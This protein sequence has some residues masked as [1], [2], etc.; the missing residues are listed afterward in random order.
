LADAA[1]RVLLILLRDRQLDIARGDPQC[2]HPIRFQ[3]DTHRI[4]GGAHDRCLPGPGD[5]L[6]GVEYENAGVVG[7][8]DGL[9][10]VVWRIDRDD[11]HHGRRLLLYRDALRLHGGG[12]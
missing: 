9:V 8:V 11:H 5:A 3:P 7:N 12:Q 2:R 4:V 1:D 10:A 6:D